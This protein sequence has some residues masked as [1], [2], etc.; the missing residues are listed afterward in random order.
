MSTDD[1]KDFGILNESRKREQMTKTSAVVGICYRNYKP[2][3]FAAAQELLLQVEK[4]ELAEMV[5]NRK[6]IMD[7]E[8]NDSN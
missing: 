6:T 5:L 7:K 1:L 3:E 8:S 2:S 4:R